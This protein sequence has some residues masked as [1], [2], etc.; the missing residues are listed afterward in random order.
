MSEESFCT[1]CGE[2]GKVLLLEVEEQMLWSCLCLEHDSMCLASLLDND[3]SELAKLLLE[4]CP[5]GVLEDMDA[6]KRSASLLAFFRAAS[7]GIS[8]SA[9]DAMRE[10]MVD[11]P[12][13]PLDIEMSVL[14]FLHEQNLL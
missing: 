3:F 6:A 11:L 1:I 9:I 14:T 4:A 5:D 13:E 12:E 2:E 10:F 8:P 7:V